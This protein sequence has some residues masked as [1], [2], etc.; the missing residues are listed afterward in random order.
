MVALT[1]D[2]ATTLVMMQAGYEAGVNVEPQCH[3]GR[4]QELSRKG[5]VSYN[6]ETHRYDVTLAGYEQAD[7]ER[8]EQYVRRFARSAYSRVESLRRQLVHAEAMEIRWRHAVTPLD[9]SE[10]TAPTG[11][12]RTASPQ[13]GA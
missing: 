12:H 9:T 7:P 8:V 10:D 13:E 5:M 3:A 11:D 1:D 4:L 6:R 2:Q